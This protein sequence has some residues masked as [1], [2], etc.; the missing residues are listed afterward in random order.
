MSLTTP[1]FDLWGSFIVRRIL[2]AVAY[3]TKKKEVSSFTRSK[4]TEG[5]P[6]FNKIGHVTLTTPPFDPKMLFFIEFRM[7]ILPS[8]FGAYKL[9]V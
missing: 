7:G 3:P 2:Q 5:V 1:P 8:K 6:K 9:F 4:V